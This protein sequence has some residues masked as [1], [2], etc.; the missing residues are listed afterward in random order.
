MLIL[1]ARCAQAKRWDEELVLPYELRQ[2]SRLRTV[3]A[4]GEDA[5]VFLDRGDVLK[6]GEFLRAEDGRVV[7]VVAR[8][9][10]VLDIVCSSAD[11][12]VRVAYHLGNRHVPLQVGLGWIR[13]AQD[14]V[15]RQMAEGLGATVI[16]REAPSSAVSSSCATSSARPPSRLRAPWNCS[17]S[18]WKLCNKVSCRSRATRSRSSTR[19]SSRALN[20]RAV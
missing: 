17:N 15:L 10:Q 3:V 7:K 2:K 20:S 12:L 9:E 8:P 4:S 5:G 18:P 14:H 1:T 13:I 16:A 6:D 19:P 11:A